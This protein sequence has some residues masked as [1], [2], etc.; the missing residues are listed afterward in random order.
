MGTVK[1]AGGES[2]SFSVGP[3]AKQGTVLGPILSSASIAECCDE[4]MWG[5]SVV[6]SLVIR[7]LGFVDDLTGL[8]GTVR[9][10]HQ[11][12][13]VV[14][15]FSKKKRI[16]LNEDK[17]LCLPINLCISE[18]TPVLFVNGKEVEICSVAK[19]LGDFFNSKGDNNDLIDDRAKKGLG[20]M[21]S[22][23]ALASEISLGIH[24]I[25]ILVLLYKIMFLTIVLFNSGAWNNITATQIK[26]ITT[27]QLKFLKRILHA[28]SS[29]TN[30]F[31]YLEL[32]IIP[33]EYN[34]HISQLNFLHHILKLDESDPVFL[35]FS[36]QKLF[37]FEKNW[38]NEVEAL[39]VKY[40]IIETEDQI[41]GMSRE[42]WKSIVKE[43]VH[44]YALDQLNRENSLKS[45]TSHHP[46]YEKLEIQE[47][48]IYL[49][50]A[51]AR[52]Y[53]QVRCQI[54]DLKT[55]R[56]YKYGEDDTRCRLCEKEDETLDHVVNKCEKIT[57]TDEV[58][59]IFSSKR[60]DVMDVVARM[61]MFTRLVEELDISAAEDHLS[62]T[63]A[64][65]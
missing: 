45:R 13:G 42:K 32:G 24:L 15:F 17:C 19:Y 51:D 5:G 52:L 11:S 1:T 49:P 9:D 63:P 39:K 27:V 20:C 29:A 47:Y 12:H 2:E 43:Y 61:K 37:Q 38:F 65:E 33:I 7:S 8:N 34:I 62:A 14:T 54:V 53:F 60:E 56:K 40:G 28:P 58:P 48:F 3:N 10:V 22:S 4:Q 6:G 31:V 23:I 41:R 59:D 64:Q 30:C 16:P 36:Q 44:V 50:P 18:A 57:R 21:I 35:A 55:L 46:E 26:K 25:K